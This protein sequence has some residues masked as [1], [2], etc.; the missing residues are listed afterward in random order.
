[1]T[2]LI[3][4]IIG[5]NNYLIG[6]PTICWIWWQS[7]MEREITDWSLKEELHVCLLWSKNP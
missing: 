5:K 6:Y 2:N 7:D 1:M 4:Q 3:L